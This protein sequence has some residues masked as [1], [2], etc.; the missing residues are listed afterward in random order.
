MDARFIA[1]LG[2]ALVA[3]SARGDESKCENPVVRL[4]F[5]EKLISVE[6]DGHEVH[7]RVEAIDGIAGPHSGPF[8]VQI[9]KIFAQH[10]ELL[11]W[12]R[13]GGTPAKTVVVRF[14]GVGEGAGLRVILEECIAA[15]VQ[16]H[17]SDGEPEGT[18]TL[19][20]ARE[21]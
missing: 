6:V 18:I 16:M 4:P 5:G 3:A 8:D 13:N 7:G 17:A 15:G 10:D 20:C 21:H 11:D 2:L 14:R 12:A 9:H 19:S 1:A